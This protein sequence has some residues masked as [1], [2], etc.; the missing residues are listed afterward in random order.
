MSLSGCSSL[1]IPW[2]WPSNPQAVAARRAGEPTAGGRVLA[3]AI[4]MIEQEAVVVGACWD[5]VNAVF[6][7]AG[8]PAARRLTVYQASEN[9]PFVDPGLLEPGDWIY[10]VNHTFGDVGHSAIF[11]DWIDLGDSRALTI[12]YVGQDRAVPGRY[13]EY[14]ISECY[15]VFRGR[16]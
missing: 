4:R 8:F 13:A 14:D 16:E 9:G 3:V 10:F 11:V 7:G 15:G 1:E 2:R 12:E 5:Y 6:T